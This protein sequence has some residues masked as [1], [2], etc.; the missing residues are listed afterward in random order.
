M[1]K[2]H[3]GCGNKHLDGYVNIDFYKS[4][5]TD[6]LLDIN[7]IDDF[8]KPNSVD[9]IYM[10]HVLEHFERAQGNL[11]IHKLFKILKP[12]GILRLAVPDWD[13]VVERY[14]ETKNLKEL[15]HILYGNHDRPLGGHFTIW[16]FDSMEKD[17]R[18]VGFRDVWRYDWRL[19]D[20]NTIDDFSRAHLPHDPEAIKTGNFNNHKLISLNIEALK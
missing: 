2:L 1:I 3:L 5:A 14:L 8:Y 11:V 9:V 13:A 18:R 19:T 4:E 16:S 12:S 7:N 20:H 17:L 6:Q 10:A 15:S